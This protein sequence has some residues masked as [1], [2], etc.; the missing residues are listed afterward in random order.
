MYAFNVQHVAGKLTE[1][2]WIW[3]LKVMHEF[4]LAAVVESSLH[5]LATL[6][7]CTNLAPTAETDS[8]ES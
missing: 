1:I 6:I 7:F 3:K 5:S 4:P 2:L 8:D